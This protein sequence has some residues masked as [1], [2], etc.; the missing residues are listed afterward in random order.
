MALEQATFQSPVQNIEIAPNLGKDPDFE[1]TGF[2]LELEM[3]RFFSSLNYLE[4]DANLRTFTIEF[5]KAG[6]VFP[7]LVAMEGNN[8]VNSYDHQRIVPKISPKE[9][10]GANVKASELVEKYFSPENRV[11]TLKNRRMGII[12]SPRG[13]NGLVG[14]YADAQ[15]VV[16]WEEPDKT[17]KGLT[18]RTDM[19]IGQS[20][21]LSVNLGVSEDSLKGTTQKEKIVNIV[22]NPAL[23]EIGSGRFNT[24]EDIF[25]EIIAIRG[26][27]DIEIKQRDGSLLKIPVADMLR[28]IRRRDELLKFSESV[29]DHLITLK[30]FI[31]KRAD[32][33]NDFSIQHE[34]ADKVKSTI[35]E[36]TRS[37]MKEDGH[38]PT[39]M[40]QVNVDWSQ[41]MTF[42][43]K[44]IDLYPN[45]LLKDNFEAEKQFLRARVG[46]AKGLSSSL[47]G[48]FGL[49]LGSL[50]GSFSSGMENIE[51]NGGSVG[52]K[53]DKTCKFCNKDGICGY[54]TDHAHL[55]D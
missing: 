29:E 8:F 1:E 38:I 45:D 35:F 20:R 30:E 34:I 53:G 31:L 12:N 26:T 3:T 32:K 55:A 5:I 46:C 19:T 6:S 18:L 2:K 33:F 48:S 41:Y 27:G 47:K 11:G 40:P 25:N 37:V 16:F 28:D 51:F 4:L 7:N 54:C 49:A 22:K 15:T 52:S 36:I 13:W 24:V 43:S 9:R 50:S 17:L 23:F 10:N 39:P 42:N 44:N 14:D 21:Q